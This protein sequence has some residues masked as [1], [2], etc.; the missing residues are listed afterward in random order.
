MVTEPRPLRTTPAPACPVCGG[1]GA[2]L[3]GGLRDALF[4]VPGEWSLRRC[5]A[6]GCGTAWLDP[7]P[8]PDD[9]GA[10]YA[11]YYTHTPGH[12]PAAPSLRK[13]VFLFLRAGYLAARYGG[14]ASPPARWLGRLLWLHPDLAARVDLEAFHL[15]G[16]V[17]GRFLEIGCGSGEHLASMRALGWDVEGVDVDPN[18]VATARARGLRVHCG[19][20]EQIGLP[21]GSFD[22]IGMSHVIEHVDDPGRLLAACRSLLRPGGRLVLVTPNLASFGHTRYGRHWLALDPPR[23]LRLY[24]CASLRATVLAA[25][26]TGEV[27]RTSVRDAH[28]QFLASTGIRRT[29]R[30]VWGTNGSLAARL[31]ARLLQWRARLQLAVLAESGEEIVL[32]ARR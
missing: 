26:F 27:T 19:A 30:W 15:G 7:R 2:A 29:G 5:A 18:A 17:G 6:A 3:Y 24:T 14:T 31:M 9:L 11:S 1:A 32:H 20:L 16:S 13:R 4:G 22:A 8:A 25:G 21:G 10:A 23:H 12:D 28:R